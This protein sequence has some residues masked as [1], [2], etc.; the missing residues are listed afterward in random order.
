[1]VKIIAI[2]NQKG[3]VGKTT[4][5]INLASCLAILDRRVLLVDCD[6][7][8]NATSGFGIDKRTIKHC[9]YDVLINDVPV[10][11]ALIHTAY[12]N[13]DLLPSTIQLAGAEI[14]MVSLMNRERRMS[15]ALDEIKH[16][17]DYILI[18]CAPSLGLLTL[19][20]LTA[21]TSVI[22]PIQC[23]FYALEG[24]TMLMNTIQLVQRNLNP[25]LKLEGVLMTMYDSR[26]KLSNEVV[27]EVR[28]FLQNK[29]YK[30]IIPRNVRLSEAPSHGEPIVFYDP[31]SVGAEKYGD[32]A[33]E[34]LENE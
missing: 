31:K 33:L 25:A 10:K 14:E 4:S 28:K 5:A 2:T 24:V 22:I 13:L 26:T 16:D 1:M 17:Y 34:V 3:G 30:T 27:S 29:V 6:P 19:N 32:L 7:Q 9:V 8:G 21:A 18:D 15:M 12:K 11:D 23:E 20:A